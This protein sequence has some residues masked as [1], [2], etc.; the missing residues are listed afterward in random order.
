MAVAPGAESRLRVNNVT[1]E[2]FKHQYK[3]Y[4]VYHQFDPAIPLK[5]DRREQEVVRAYQDV[6]TRED[7]VDRAVFH[8]LA[9]RFDVYQ[10]FEWVQSSYAPLARVSLQVVK[11]ERRSEP[12][13]K[14]TSLAVVTGALGTVTADGGH[15]TWHGK[16]PSAM[17][18]AGMRRQSRVSAPKT[19]SKISVNKTAIWPK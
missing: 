15:P 3:F 9:D 8:M 16:F 6:Q 7:W 4:H 12:D 2:E 10:G 13:G 14:Q 18:A 11:D 5:I 17:G 19:P 1:A